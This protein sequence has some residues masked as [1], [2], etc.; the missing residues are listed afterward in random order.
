MRQREFERELERLRRLQQIVLTCSDKIQPGLGVSVERKRLEQSRRYAQHLFS[1]RQLV[2]QDPEWLFA[3]LARP[4]PG[5]ATK[6]R[7]QWCSAV[8]TRRP[9]A[10]E[11]IH[12]AR[13]AVHT[14]VLRPGQGLR[15]VQACRAPSRFGATGTECS[16][17]QPLQRRCQHQLTRQTIARGVS[18]IKQII[19][20]G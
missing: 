5:S 3:G 10:S 7:R 18:R 17:A 13:P 4:L 12:P 15:P 1:L 11:M 16:L 14:S 8:R 20:P 9:G 6:D 19:D 2:V